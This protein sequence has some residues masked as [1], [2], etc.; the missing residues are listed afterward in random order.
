MRTRST[1]VEEVSDSGLPGQFPTKQ[2]P[3]E[4][5]GNRGFQ[6]MTMSVA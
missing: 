6:Q 2:E 4:A 3:T 5:T 1:P